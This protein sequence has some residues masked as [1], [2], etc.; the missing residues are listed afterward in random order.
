MVYR[1][2]DLSLT[3]LHSEWPKLYRVLAI[4][5]AI[6]LKSHLK[7]CGTLEAQWVKCWPDDL[8]GRSSILVGGR[9]L[10]KHKLGF[11]HT[12]FLYHPPSILIQLKYCYKG[13]KIPSSH[14]PS[15]WKTGPG[16]GGL[17][18]TTLDL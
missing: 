2:V 3:L 15:M 9:N 17:E 18:Q 6:G 5:R 8:A 13:R 11:L 10:F 14:H 1:G 16:D 4:L 12:D 7:D